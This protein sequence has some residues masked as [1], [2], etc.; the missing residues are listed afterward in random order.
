[1]PNPTPEEFAALLSLSIAGVFLAGVIAL[2]IWLR[3][4]EN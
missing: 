1:M 2:G 3:V 4:R